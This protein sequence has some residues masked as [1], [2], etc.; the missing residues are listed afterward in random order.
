VCVCVCVRVCVCVCTRAQ[1]TRSNTNTRTLRQS[2]C[3]CVCVC[4]C[5]QEHNPQDLIQIHTTEIESATKLL[6][7]PEI[8]I[9]C[10][11][12]SKISEMHA[13]HPKCTRCTKN[14]NRTLYYQS[15]FRKRALY[16]HTCVPRPRSHGSFRKSYMCIHVYIPKN[17]A[18]SVAAKS[19]WCEVVWRDGA[20]HCGVEWCNIV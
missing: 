5:P 11:E 3:V 18:L 10:T 9:S 15:S 8:A 13:S 17:L 16:I 12:N 20:V 4:V 6:Y 7:N 14:S 2:I 1:P 19:C